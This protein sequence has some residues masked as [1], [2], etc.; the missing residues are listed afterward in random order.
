MRP[1]DSTT[2]AMPNWPHL[3]VSDKEARSGQKQIKITAVKWSGPMAGNYFHVHYTLLTVPD[4]VE[5]EGCVEVGPNATWEQVK[6]AIVTDITA[7]GFSGSSV[8][9]WVTH[10]TKRGII[11]Q[12]LRANRHAKGET[13]AHMANVMGVTSRSIRAWEANGPGPLPKYINKLVEAGYL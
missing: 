11:G 13:M 5:Y 2:Q 9:A 12:C 4:K 6:A 3:A 1:N 7:A 10:P 8:M